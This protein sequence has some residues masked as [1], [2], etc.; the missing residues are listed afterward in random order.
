VNKDQAPTVLANQE[1]IAF[2]PDGKT[3]A[4]AIAVQMPMRL[5]DVMTGMER[6]KGTPA[7]HGQNARCRPCPLRG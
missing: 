4:V 1:E 7:L 5:L 3:L 2:S 6:Q